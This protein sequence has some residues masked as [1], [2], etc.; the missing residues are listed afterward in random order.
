MRGPD[1]LPFSR[2][3]RFFPGGSSSRNLWIRRC[4]SHYRA[5][6][7]PSG[8]AGLRIHQIGKKSDQEFA[9]SLGATW[10]GGSD[11]LPP[12]ELDAAIIFAPVGSLVVAAL[13]AV[14]KEAGLFVGASI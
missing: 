1:W 7:C 5:S 13:R 10:A 11:E 6:R 3:G 12:D 2:D 14:K 4:G 9:R 8:P